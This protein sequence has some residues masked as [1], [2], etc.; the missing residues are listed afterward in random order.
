[1]K[2]VFKKKKKKQ[3]FKTK[4]NLHFVNQETSKGKKKKKK[5]KK[6][7]TKVLVQLKK[8]RIEK[9][10]TQ[11]EKCGCIGTGRRYRSYKQG[12]S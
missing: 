10:E 1:M 8:N 4:T 11:L 12:G 9:F 2:F 7:W 5:K 6:K 3:V